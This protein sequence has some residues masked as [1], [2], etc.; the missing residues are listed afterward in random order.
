VDN[1]QS[2]RAR[3]VNEVWQGTGPFRRPSRGEGEGGTV[4]K[5]IIYGVAVVG[6]DGEVN[7][8]FAIW[9]VE[10]RLKTIRASETP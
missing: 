8:Q 3:E 5:E 7:L 6:T 4:R 2:K 1:Y 10:G 9:R